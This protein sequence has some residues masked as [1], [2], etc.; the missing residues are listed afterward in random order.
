MGWEE[1]VGQVV[2]VD[3]D[4]MFVYIGTLKEVDDQFVTLVNVDAHDVREAKSTK[5]QYVIDT[6]KYGVNPNRKEARVRKAVVV[7]VSKLS[8]IVEY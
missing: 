5:E 3:T 6:K 4:S 2:V 8:D 1:L 7:S